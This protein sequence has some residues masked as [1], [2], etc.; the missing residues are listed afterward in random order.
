MEIIERVLEAVLFVVA[1]Q[2]GL[3]LFE[4][5]GQQPGKQPGQ[6]PGKQP[7]EPPLA[8]ARRLIRRRMPVT[9][10]VITTLL[11]AGGVLQAIWPG[12]LDALRQEPHGAW[13]RPFTAPFVQTGGG[14]AGALFNI[15]TAA[16]IVALAEWQWG[17]LLAA[18]IWLTGA[19]APV[20]DVARLAGYHVSAADAFAY[21]AGS[22]GATYFTAATLCAALLCCGTSRAR[23]AGLAGPAIAL[24]M[25][26]AT[27]DG[28][29]VLFIEGF[30]LG[31][32]LLAARTS[33]VRA[34]EQVTRDGGG[35]DHVERVDPGRQSARMH[36][37]ADGL[38]GLAQPA[39]R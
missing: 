20:G 17:R 15:V 12:A 35:R 32:L 3:R 4:Q 33:L 21:S 18:A 34:H 37:D 9:A 1:A 10:I 22:S 25:W 29:G 19:W 7:G 2:S 23:L 38:V 31:L 13:W 11:A 5:P 24:V 36:R 27:N 6:Q 39:R 16:I 28:H 14:L 30:V 8:L 26:F